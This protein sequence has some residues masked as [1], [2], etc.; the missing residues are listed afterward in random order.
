[1]VI[2]YDGAE[3]MGWHAYGTA[4]VLRRNV[5]VAGTDE[6]I[7]RYEGPVLSDRRLCD[8][9]ERGAIVVLMNS[10]GQLIQ[11][12]TYEEYGIPSDTNN[13]IAG[14]AISRRGGSANLHRLLSGVSA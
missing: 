11:R 1:M 10:V 14:G 3:M 4:A 8:A 2:T 6:P 13:E 5:Y 7:V 9:D 12:M